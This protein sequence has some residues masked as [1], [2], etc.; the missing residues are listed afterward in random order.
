MLTIDEE[1]IIEFTDKY[2]NESYHLYL[3]QEK[4]KNYV[5]YVSD[6]VSVNTTLWDSSIQAILDICVGKEFSQYQPFF[7]T[8]RRIKK[9][10]QELVRITSQHK[11]I[12]TALDF[13]GIDLI[14]L[15]L[16]NMY[17]PSTFK[18]LYYA[19]TGVQKGRYSFKANNILKN[20][21]EQKNKI[22]DKIKRL[23]PKAQFLFM[24]LFVENEAFNKPSRDLFYRKAC[25]NSPTYFSSKGTL[26][27]YL[28][29]V[30]FAEVPA[31]NEFYGKYVKIIKNEI[32]SAQ[33]T[34]EIQKIFGKYKKIQEP[35]WGAIAEHANQFKAE[36]IFSLSLLKALILFAIGQLNKY[37]LSCEN[38][39]SRN[40]SFHYKLIIYIIILS[41]EVAETDKRKTLD[42]ILKR[43]PLEMVIIYICDAIFFK[44]IIAR[45]TS[46]FDKNLPISEALIKYTKFNAP[47]TDDMV[48]NELRDISR[49]IYSFF[50]ETF[51]GKS[52]WNEFKNLPLDE[53]QE[54]HS[55]DEKQLGLFSLKFFI[56][57]Q[58]GSPTEG[59][60]CYDLEDDEDKNE[61]QTKF[62]GYIEIDKDK[63]GIQ[64]DFSQYLVSDCFDI[65]KLG[66]E[67]CFDFIEFM[68]ISILGYECSM[69]LNNIQNNSKK[70]DETILTHIMTPDKLKEYWE[71]YQN[72][73]S[74]SSVFDG[75]K[76]YI[77][78]EHIID[79]RRVRDIV[80]QSL[81]DMVQK[82]T[83]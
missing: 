42:I 27:R 46:E 8:P 75:K 9:I 53:I 35:L 38:I 55:E 10:L 58:I 65:D 41:N 32:S 48:K 81:D 2:I 68:L 4:I 54:Y 26:E 5:K 22:E 57:N 72:T 44:N 20:K 18:Q 82:K 1:K 74:Y 36:K 24:Q 19:E 79:A 39:I 49:R 23:P 73:I 12:D 11:N 37:K 29:L 78:K 60:S 17:Y 52:L 15:L 14:N 21:K 61:I 63:C 25:F 76:F 33:N 64:K 47:N 69:N 62:S 34:K 70:F 59:L 77:D 28:Q 67:A 30:A 66:E 43:T 7:S 80:A 83:V 50:T 51:Q 45:H 3:E 16:L 56:L 31:E 13:E 40:T 71:T 6:K